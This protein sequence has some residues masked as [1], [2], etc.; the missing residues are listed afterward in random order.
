L[1]A[2]AELEPLVG[3]AED[4]LGRSRLLRLS[5]ALAASPTLLLLLLLLVVS[6]ARED[7]EEE[8]FMAPFEALLPLLLLPPFLS[9][10]PDALFF[11]SLLVLVLVVSSFTHERL[12]TFS[13]AP[14]P[15]AIT[16]NPSISAVAL[17]FSTPSTQLKIAFPA[18]E[19]VGYSWATF[20]RNLSADLTCM[21]SGDL[22]HEMAIVRNRVCHIL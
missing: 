3:I 5:P 20:V 15:F 11:L 21:Y 18:V 8:L 6:L 1:E 14:T 12:R 17:P 4:E 9:L 2:E 16:F 22:R 19:R 7:E 10:L 13:R